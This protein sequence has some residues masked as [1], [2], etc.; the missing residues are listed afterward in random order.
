MYFYLTFS[1]CFIYKRL[2]NFVLS[3]VYQC[4]CMPTARLFV[5]FMLV[6]YCVFG[7]QHLYVDSVI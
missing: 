7:M 3:H 2:L 1:A 6:K 4:I 5:T